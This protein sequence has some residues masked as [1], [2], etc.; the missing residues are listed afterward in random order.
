MRSSQRGIENKLSGN[1]KGL[2]KSQVKHTI[3]R[4]EILFPCWITRGGTPTG[5]GDTKRAPPHHLS[6]SF[7]VRIERLTALIVL[8]RAVP[9]LIISFQREVS[10]PLAC[11]LAARPVTSCA[12]LSTRALHKCREGSQRVSSL[13]PSLPTELCPPFVRNST[14]LVVR[15]AGMRR[16]QDIQDVAGVSRG[17][18][19]GTTNQPSTGARVEAEDEVKKQERFQQ[20]EHPTRRFQSEESTSRHNLSSKGNPRQ[21][22]YRG[23]CSSLRYMGF[24]IY[25]CSCGSTLAKQTIGRF[26]T[27][28]TDLQA[29]GPSQQRA[30]A[31]Q[32]TRALRNGDI[33]VGGFIIIRQALCGEFLFCCIRENASH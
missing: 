30:A 33:H 31:R 13:S 19:A 10:N 22:Q 2:P 28:N 7:P 25:S 1:L 12:H 29:N 9:R 20:M 24:R 23:A 21:K 3:A 14:D 5:H 8:G 4:G 26:A 17:G 15:H 11:H 27:C 32:R 16:S 6:A 18:L